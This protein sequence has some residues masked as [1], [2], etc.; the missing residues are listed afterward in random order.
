MR[1]LL[2]MSAVLTTRERARLRRANQ[3]GAK[4][5]L[6]VS[7]AP[8]DSTKWLVCERNEAAPELVTEESPVVYGQKEWTEAETGIKFLTRGTDFADAIAYVERAALQ[9]G[10]A[11]LYRGRIEPDHFKGLW[12]WYQ[13]MWWRHGKQLRGWAIA[14]ACLIL[15]SV[16]ANFLQ[17]YA[18]RRETIDTLRNRCV[19]AETNAAFFSRALSDGLRMPLP[20]LMMPTSGPR[21]EEARAIALDYCTAD[22]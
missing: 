8:Y 6:I 7:R 21:Y 12:R 3:L 2:E 13:L 17:N 14:L 19:V 15:V 10:L 18:D 5:S 16:V 9:A 4:L 22:G 20:E 1:E 11:R